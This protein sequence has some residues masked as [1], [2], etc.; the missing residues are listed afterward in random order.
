MEQF[1]DNA[2][3][4]MERVEKRGK[5]MSQSFR[6]VGKQLAIA[7]T[8][9][10]GVATAAVVFATREAIQFQD[11][12][13]LVQK[14]VDAT[15][16]QMEGLAGGV[17]QMATE[18][19]VGVNELNRMASVAGQLG[20]ETD[21]IL[22]FTR[23]VAEMGVATDLAG[24]DAAFALAR[25]SKVT[26]LPQDEVRNLAS[27][28]VDLGN[29]AAATESEIVD[30]ALGL[31]GVAKQAD[32]GVP[33]ILAL[34]TTVRELG[35][36]SQTSATAIQKTVVGMVKAVKGGGQELAGFAKIAG[37]TVSEFRRL[38][39]QDAQAALMQFIEGVGRLGQDAI[40]IMDEIGLGNERALKTLITL[41]SGY[42]SVV[43]NVD[44][45]TTAMREN[46]ALSDEASRRFETMASQLQI[47]RNILTEV[48]IRIGERILPFLAGMVEQLRA[49]EPAI[50]NFADAIGQKVPAAFMALAEGAGI[51]SRTVTGLRIVFVT[52]KG[53]VVGLIQAIAALV[54]GALAK[55]I[56]GVAKVAS[57]GAKLGAVSQE[58]VNSIES[59]AQAFEDFASGAMDFAIDNIRGM[60]DEYVSALDDQAAFERGLDKV[61]EAMERAAGA[62]STYGGTLDLLEEKHKDLSIAIETPTSRLQDFEGWLRTTRSSIGD[63]GAG[64]DNYVS[65]LN[66]TR[67][68]LVS[69]IAQQEGASEAM[70][71]FAFQSG[72]SLEKIRAYARG[73]ASTDP[74]VRALTEEHIRG[75]IEFQKYGFQ[76]KET[77]SEIEGVFKRIQEGFGQAIAD[78]I[79]KGESFVD[80]IKSLFM[81]LL[82]TIVTKFIGGLTS[83]FANFLAGS[84]NSLFS[85]I[86]GLLGGSP[87]GMGFGDVFSMFGLGGGGGGGGNVS[88][89]L[90]GLLGGG[91]AAPSFITGGGFGIGAIGAGG[92]P[93]IGGA[94][95]GAGGAA[96]GGG[97]GGLFSSI[98]GFLSST[99]GIATLGIGAAVPLLF[100]LFGGPS[101]AEKGAEE[102]GRILG[103]RIA[104][105]LPEAMLEQIGNAEDRFTA[106]RTAIAQMIQTVGITA[107]EIPKVIQG[108]DEL[109]TSLRLGEI[110]ANGFGAAMGNNISAIIGEM[111]RLGATQPQ[112]LD[113]GRTMS[114]SLNLVKKGELDARVAA[115]ALRRMFPAMSRSVEAF[116]DAGIRVLK[117]IV[118]KMERNKIE[119]VQ[120]WRD[121]LNEMKGTTDQMEK[122]SEQTSRRIADDH[123]KM[124]ELVAMSWEKLSA[125]AQE[126]IKETGKISVQTAEAIR[127]KFGQS[128]SSILDQIGSIRD[129]WAGLE[130]EL[131]GASIVPDIRRGI[132]REFGLAMEAGVGSA[133]AIASA[134]SSAGRTIDRALKPAPEGG[135]LRPIDPGGI[136]PFTSLPFEVAPGRRGA[137]PQ[138]RVNMTL[139]VQPEV[140]T[141][142]KELRRVAVDLKRFLDDEDRGAL[143]RR[144]VKRTG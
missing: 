88:G 40:P 81:G 95:A 117:K 52:I 58:T 75:R 64:L 71:R 30:T 116:G 22:E 98:G 10:T 21:S 12:F 1:G 35:L 55:L 137:P 132:E 13:A 143:A 34:A 70:V 110:S 46:T 101:P 104:A 16:Q 4:S 29:N 62:G 37:T 138:K 76:V 93:L 120:H 11:S 39:E 142:R 125:R 61:K 33:A 139:N 130:N 99:A 108:T 134:Y 135:P 56:S 6:D 43:A 106:T 131:V 82:D 77:G 15:T 18:I 115:D 67:D 91:A 66:T 121:L 122:K 78:M 96:A 47:L 79:L 41:G 119:G 136:R 49:N 92:F 7:A 36:E 90:G 59:T 32:I 23:V 128:T 141:D 27:A 25:I 123:A 44:R 127:S 28:I 102:V 86:G 80:K 20:V 74:R 2:A 38:F 19:P 124:A 140:L 45:A 63:V 114:A 17:R 68:A 42:D 72:D 53:V 31:A 85:A 94:G 103:G 133:A 54:T 144:G 50:L 3:G 105:A 14:T 57:I 8:A 129:R 26:D 83:A 65:G 97:L 48:G 100:S 111:A 69:I 60:G 73:L 109:V 113:L 112:I 107:A 118:R 87:G 9:I 5:T 24:D 51:A 89:L 126:E 84:G